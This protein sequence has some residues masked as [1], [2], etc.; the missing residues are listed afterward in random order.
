MPIRLDDSDASFE[1]AFKDLL[2][3]KREASEEVDRV[4]ADIIAD[5]R[6]RGD[7]AVSGDIPVRAGA[8]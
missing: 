7:T 2:G 5:V 4:V 1:A 8:K 6:Q 3:A